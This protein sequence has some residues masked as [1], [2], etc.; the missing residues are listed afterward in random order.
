[1]FY[2][3]APIC[4]LTGLVIPLAKPSALH[5]LDLRLLEAWHCAAPISIIVLCIH[6]FISNISAQRPLTM[7]I[8]EQSDVVHIQQLDSLQITLLSIQHT[9]FPLIMFRRH[10]M[11]NAMP[12]S[13]AFTITVSAWIE[14]P[15][16]PG[17][18][19]LL[20]TLC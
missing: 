7:C 8:Q 6:S 2:G 1:M 3:G 18:I 19:Q 9:P 11:V 5:S 15:P 20:R 14:N 10:T 17:A 16:L 12:N 13:I 4:V